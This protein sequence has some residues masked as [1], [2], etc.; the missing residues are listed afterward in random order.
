MLSSL[1]IS[2][3]ITTNKRKNVVFSN[4]EY[5]CKE[6][7]DINISSGRSDF[8]RLIGFIQKYK[9]EKIKEV[10]NQNI[11]PLILKVKNF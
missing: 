5:S 10:L 9:Q 6:S 4:G 7:Y 11:L 8:K 2:S 3:Y 1:G